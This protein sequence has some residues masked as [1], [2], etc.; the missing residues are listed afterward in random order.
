MVGAADSSRIY[1]K[2]TRTTGGSGNKHL[3]HL[4]QMNVFINDIPLIIKKA[5]EKMPGQYDAVID[6]EEYFSSK[7][8]AG[9]VL[10]KSASIEI[11]DKLVR[12]MEVKRLKKLQSLT[13]VTN[14]KRRLVEH[15][16]DQFK[17]VKA[18][19][20]LI[21]HE[22]KILMI[23]RLGKWDLP[24]GKLR[25]SED[26]QM[27]AIREV[28]EECNIQVEVDG[29]L[30][31]TWHSYAYKGKK[32]LKKTTWY[33]MS[34]TDQSLMKPQAEEFI[35]E[36]RFLSIAEVK[37]VMPHTYTSIQFVLNHYLQVVKSEKE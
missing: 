29:K 16:K 13:L 1:R 34:C 3:Q 4:I 18:A 15:L 10:I 11:I 12:I 5:G 27:G 21:V 25:Q 31:N 24:K 32:V 14:K 2:L 17:I 28:A 26:K 33:L 19:G 36:V 35:E 30:L 7:S 9:N 23:Y 6:S 20:G 37:E 8:L 22:G